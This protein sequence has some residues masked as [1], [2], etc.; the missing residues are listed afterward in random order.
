MRI[1]PL[2]RKRTPLLLF[3]FAL[4]SSVAHAAITVDGVLDEPEWQQAQSCDQWKRTEPYT[5]DE[6]RYH[7]AAH[8]VSTDAGL[9]VAFV[10]DQPPE[11]HRVKPR[12]PRDSETLVGDS[13]G[14]MVDFDGTGQVAYEF[15]VGLGG[16]T[17]DGLIT[18]QN[19]FDRDWD[20]V[21][22]HA[23]RETKDQWIVEMLI[24]WTTVTMRSA[25][26]R[27]HT[28]GVFFNRY[29]YDRK[30]RYTCPGVSYDNPAM[31]ADF[32]RIEIDRPSAS[33]QF[34]LVP[35]VT[36][37]DDLVAHD[38]HLKA[39]GDLFWRPSSNLQLAATLNPDFGQ[40][41]SDE[42]V[43][44]FS[45]IETVLTDKRP[46]FTQN[47]ALFDLRT[48]ANGQ[49]IYTRRVGGAPDDFSAGSSEINSA[50][51]ATGNVGP[52]SYGAFAAEE[53]NYGDGVGR[54][55]SAARLAWPSSIGRFG[56]LATYT[57][58]PYLDR[59]ALVNA[60]DF[61][62]ANTSSS[63][64][65]GQIVRSDIDVG[66]NGTSGWLGWLE[67]DFNR[68]SPLSFVLKALYIDR[69]FDMND[70]GYLERNNLRQVEVDTNYRRMPD[71]PDVTGL[72]DRLYLLYRSDDSGHLLQTSRVQIRREV[73]YA[74]SWNAYAE[75]RYLPAGL[76]DLI[77]R[78]NGPVNI[79]TRT[80]AYG[81]FDTPRYGRWQFSG[82]AYTQQIGV[83]GYSLYTYGIGTWYAREDLTLSAE[84]DP[85]ISGDWLLWQH[86]NVF[87]TYRAN[88][89]DYSFRLDWIPSP[90]HELRIK[91]QWI[92][93]DARA[94]QGWRTDARGDLKRTADPIDDFT[95]NNLGFQIRYRYSLNDLS[96]LFLVYSRGG[97]LQRSP[98]DRPLADLAGSMSDVRDAE[99]LL[100]KFSYR[101]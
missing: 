80:L 71:D 23:V 17:R 43:V 21:W 88:R 33:T 28:I 35:Y 4:C 89:I 68:S 75:F 66:K 79:G 27:H 49:L 99:Q 47:Q 3:V 85:Q 61:D 1:S 13:V 14:F 64:T 97:Y 9:A 57:E 6:P 26:E 84:I 56:Y 31:M 96:D 38:L 58:R 8:V 76:D 41:E 30:E 42:L 48:P 44:N 63:R 90:H 50:L 25:G 52:I 86:D 45:A 62:L 12:T 65:S 36:A 40:V 87:G 60:F 19:Q 18:N 54:L 29:L 24:P 83:S 10:L 92:G 7:N 72:R 98:D 82:G 95:V 15:S 70:L 59:Q 46:F 37:I 5:L 91:W 34:D 73:N 81:A 67:Q 2:R 16:G 55:F 101:L 22:Q 51:K 78:G 74:S 53:R 32:K 69:R 39:G 93:I 11:A 77:S 20:G 100:L 94:Q